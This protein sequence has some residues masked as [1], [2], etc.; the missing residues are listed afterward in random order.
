MNKFKIP[1]AIK[2][3]SN[4]PDIYEWTCGGTDAGRKRV[5]VKYEIHKT[6]NSIYADNFSY[7]LGDRYWNIY[8]FRPIQFMNYTHFKN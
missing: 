2:D 4:Y 6:H 5:E 3:I 1:K 8:Q 7:T